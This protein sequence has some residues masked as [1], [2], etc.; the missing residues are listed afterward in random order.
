MQI[1]VYGY[2]CVC[3]S[4]PEKQLT[5]LLLLLDKCAWVEGVLPELGRYKKQHCNRAMKRIRGLISY[6]KKESWKFFSQKRRLQKELSQY[7][8]GAYKK[9]GEWLFTRPCGSRTRGSV[10]KQKEGRFRL[11]IKKGGG[12]QN[13]VA[14]RSCGCPIPVSIQGQVGQSCEQHH[15]VKGVPA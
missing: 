2:V 3:L 8:K 4:V 13:Q 6:R 10:L 11:E 15:L 7:I 9:D 12:T 5:R 1:N 14:R